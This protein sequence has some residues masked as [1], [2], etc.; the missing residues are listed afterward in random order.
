VGPGLEAPGPWRLPS[1]NVRSARGPAANLSSEAGRGV[2][3]PPFPVEL[4]DPTVLALCQE[5]LARGLVADV[6]VAFVCGEPDVR[7]VVCR[8]GD[9]LTVELLGELATEPV[10]AH[11][12]AVRVQADR[13]EVFQG[14][15]Y[16]SARAE[17]VD[18][19]AALLTSRPEQAPVPCTRLG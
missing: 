6:R 11:W 8:N 5:F 4:V 16:G 17:V 14:P 9:D 10:P 18:F 1:G 3:V 19:V 15:R 13:R 12:A 2:A 7:L